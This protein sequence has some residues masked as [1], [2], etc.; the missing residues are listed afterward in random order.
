M[1]NDLTIYDKTA[2]QWW[3]DDIRWVRTLRNMVPG[4]LSW[5][6]RQIDWAGKDVLD[7]GCAGGF[8][9]EAMAL[10][11]ANVTGI[12]PAAEAIEAAVYYVVAESLT[13]AAK[14][15][16]A[17]EAWVELST[18]TETVDVGDAVP[19]AIA[20]IAPRLQWAQRRHGA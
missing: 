8:M 13:N 15:S 14:H 19:A 10:R 16:D 1:R 9:A 11:G 3:T 2:A 17:S 20:E 5:M 4:R 18:T 12:D 6:D 7:L